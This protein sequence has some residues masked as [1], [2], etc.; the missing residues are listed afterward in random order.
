SKIWRTRHNVGI[1]TFPLELLVINVL[2]EN[3]SGD[4]EVRF[5]RV[6]DAFADRMNDL[7]IEDPAN[8]YGND[9]SHALT[10]A[11]RRE[12]AKAASDTRDAVD[13]Y[14]WA[15]AFGESGNKQAVPNVNII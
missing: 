13:S 5:R 15:H 3:G 2:H 8:P 12:V 6:L 4:I 10:N 7:Q 11:I 14:G 1:K 9:L